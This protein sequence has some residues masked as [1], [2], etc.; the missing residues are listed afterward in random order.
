MPLG[1]KLKKQTSIAEKQYQKFDDDKEPK[2]TDDKEPI[3]KK[4]NRSNLTYNRDFTSLIRGLG[5][6]LCVALIL[7]LF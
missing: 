6:K 1:S 2:T 7:F 4:H 5:A 3:V